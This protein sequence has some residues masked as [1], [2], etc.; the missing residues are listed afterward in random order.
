MQ[1]C[2]TGPNFYVTIAS[3]IIL[4][5]HMG[6]FPAIF[7]RFFHDKEHKEKMFTNNRYLTIH[8]YINQSIYSINLYVNNFMCDFIIRFMCDIVIDKMI[9][10][11]IEFKLSFMME[12]F[13]IEW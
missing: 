11:M 13:M 2:A 9:Y 1:E 4:L 12:S 6:G 3:V 10:M 8:L 5:V 7:F